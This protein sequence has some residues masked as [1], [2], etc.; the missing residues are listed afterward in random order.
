MW[1]RRRGGNPARAAGVWLHRLPLLGRSNGALRPR[2]PRCLEHTKLAGHV[3]IRPPRHLVAVSPLRL[4]NENQIGRRRLVDLALACLF[5]AGE[6]RLPRGAKSTLSPLRMFPGQ[7]NPQGLRERRF[8]PLQSG[9]RGRHLPRPSGAPLQLPRRSGDPIVHRHQCQKVL[10]PLSQ[11][12][13]QAAKP[14]TRPSVVAGRQAG[15]LRR[16][17]RGNNC[18]TPLMTLRVCQVNPSLPPHRVLH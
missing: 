17:G 18:T 14:I 12:Q 2:H 7:L 9:R 6:R 3:T 13:D 11:H 4:R 8:H 15:C 5:R 10:H 1:Q 16:F